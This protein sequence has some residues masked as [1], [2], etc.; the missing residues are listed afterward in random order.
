MILADGDNRFHVAPQGTRA[1]PKSW[2]VLVHGRGDA[3]INDRRV[4]IDG[5]RIV[6]VPAM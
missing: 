3:V 5:E 1:A 6:E 2:R 4:R